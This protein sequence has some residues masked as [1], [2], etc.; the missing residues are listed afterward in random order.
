MQSER[1]P[2]LVQAPYCKGK[3]SPIR[4]GKREPGRASDHFASLKAAYALAYVAAQCSV[5]ASSLGICL[6]C[7]RRCA[8][9]L[10]IR[11]AK[12]GDA[13]AFHAER[14]GGGG[15]CSRVRKPENIFQRNQTATA[16]PIK[17]RDMVRNCWG[18]G[19]MRQGSTDRIIAGDFLPD[20]RNQSVKSTG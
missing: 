17:N 9:P 13:A 3:R 2:G 16:R 10:L 14:G 4:E 15:D 20:D 12:K 6:R 5:P 11:R 7:R 8:A 19:D 18:G 1:C